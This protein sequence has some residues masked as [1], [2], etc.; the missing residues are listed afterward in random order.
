MMTYQMKIVIYIINLIKWRIIMIMNF[1]QM[2]NNNIAILAWTTCGIYTVTYIVM[3][4]INK[5]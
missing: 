4:Y 3:Y 2:L 5:F 1:I